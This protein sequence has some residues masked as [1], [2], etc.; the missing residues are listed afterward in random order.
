MATDGGSAQMYG[1]SRRHWIQQHRNQDTSRL[2]STFVYVS[3]MGPQPL[4]IHS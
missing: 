4:S 1:S 3:R 2:F